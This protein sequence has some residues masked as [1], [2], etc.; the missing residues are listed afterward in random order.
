MLNLQNN[1]TIR[2]SNDKVQKN[3]NSV[4]PA[5]GIIKS[6]LSG[7]N[8]ILNKQIKPPKPE[9]KRDEELEIM[10]TSLA[11]QIIGLNKL[12]YMEMNIN[13]INN[14]YD[15]FIKNRTKNNS[16][17]LA[18]DILIKIKKINE[19]FDQNNNINQNNINQN[20]I[21][22]NNINQNNINQNNIHQ[23]NINQ[24]NIQ[25]NNIKKNNEQNNEKNNEKNNEIN[26]EIIL[27]NITSERKKNKILNQIIPEKNI[28]INN[29][30]IMNENDII[31]K[32][33]NEFLKN[34]RINIL[35]QKKIDYTRET[36]NININDKLSIINGQSYITP[37][38][39]ILD[40][41]I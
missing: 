6:Q 41:M 18:Y 9:I 32:T 21:N 33:S 4:S 39:F 26:N 14:Y 3:V 12:N 5:L 24:N 23:N 35:N 15:N 30:I 28:I 11:L 37:N 16:F 36:Q 8:F 34:K 25:K 13:Q 17:K 40:K 20:N 31:L 27:N 1:S 38:E 2:L 19:K 10:S 29:N 22:Q 7:T